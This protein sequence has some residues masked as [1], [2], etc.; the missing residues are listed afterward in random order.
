[1]RH[2]PRIACAVS[3]VPEYIPIFACQRLVSV[4][5]SSS[6]TRLASGICWSAAVQAHVEIGAEQARAGMTQGSRCDWKERV[7][8][9]GAF[10][11]KPLRGL[12]DSIG[13]G[14]SQ[15]VVAGLHGPSRVCEHVEVSACLAE[16]PSECDS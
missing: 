11:D 10:Y 3:W 9:L 7:A 15:I 1:M 2:E 14:G 5:E 12:V 13:N 16:R 6:T 4:I 8:A